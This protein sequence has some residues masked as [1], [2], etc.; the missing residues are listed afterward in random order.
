MEKV[1]KFLILNLK[2]ARSRSGLSQMGLADCTGLSPGFIG[3]IESGR[4]LPS[5]DSL[6]RILDALKLEPYEIFLDPHTDSV[7]CPQEK[8]CL[9]RAALIDEL[10]GIVSRTFADHFEDPPE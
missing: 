5:A 8:I 3:D 6:Q 2:K 7:P 10:D 9:V 4:K 1:Q